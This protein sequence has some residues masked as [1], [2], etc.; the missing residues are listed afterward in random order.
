[1]MGG[2]VFNGGG[3]GKM[4]YD[5]ASCGR[6]MNEL[7]FDSIVER[8]CSEDETSPRPDHPFPSRRRII[9][10]MEKIRAAIFPAYFGPHELT[11]ANMRFHVG[12]TLFSIGRILEEQ[13]RFGM[14]FGCDRDEGL[15]CE[16]CR[17]KAAS[18]CREFVSSLPT[19]REALLLDARAAYEG[20]PA[21]TSASEAVFCYP[22]MFALTN[23]RVAHRLH[24]LG[25][26]IIPRII[27]EYAHS[28]TGIDIH[29]GA[30]IGRRCFIDHGTG[31]VIGETCII[32]NDVRIY[33]GVTL[34]AKS[35]PLDK[36]GKPIKGIPRHP[37]VEDEVIIYSGATILGRITIGRGS[38][39]GGNVW[40]TESCPPY[41]RILL[42]PP[43]LVRKEGK[44]PRSG[45][46]VGS[47]F[48]RD[49]G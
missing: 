23:Y 45:D 46:R 40:L 38:V 42:S 19:I 47:V 3:G 2:R 49:A 8:L 24:E 13:V 6:W 1:M 18:V 37:I 12:D 29:P 39:I 30:E 20:D 35:F 48:R 4:S 5:G 33:Q 15:V 16:E 14:C 44:P 43:K 21:A 27:T 22:G 17:G 34:G 11:A 10:L 41:S 32:G 26:P 31:V 9:E 7:D 36:D 28:M 25:V